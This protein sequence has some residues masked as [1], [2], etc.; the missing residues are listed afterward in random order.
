MEPEEVKQ[1]RVRLRNLR[2]EDEEDEEKYEEYDEEDE[3]KYEEYE[4]DE[5]KQL[6]TEIQRPTASTTFNITHN[7]MKRG[8]YSLPVLMA[9]LA[10]I[11]RDSPDALNL[12]YSI[13]STNN[14]LFTTFFIVTLKSTNNAIYVKG[15]Q[16]INNTI[17]L[18]TIQLFISYI[19]SVYILLFYKTCTMSY[20]IYINKNSALFIDKMKKFINAQIDNFSSFIIESVSDL[21]VNRDLAREFISDLKVAANKNL[22]DGISLV[23][24]C[25]SF[26]ISD[27][28]AINS[29][30]SHLRGLISTADD[31]LFVEGLE[32]NYE[33]IQNY[34]AEQTEIKINEAKKG[35][36]ES[37]TDFIS[38]SNIQESKDEDEEQEFKKDLKKLIYKKNFEEINNKLIQRSKK[39]REKI[40]SGSSS[41]KSI[42]LYEN[43]LG[44]LQKPMVEAL[45]Y[46]NKL[47]EAQNTR[48][49]II[50]FL[51]NLEVS[52]NKIDKF[53][54]DFY[55]F[56]GGL[57]YNTGDIVNKTL[58]DESTLQMKNLLTKYNA[59]TIGEQAVK[60]GKNIPY[61]LYNYIVKGETSLETVRTG[62]N[63]LISNFL[64]DLINSEFV[65]NSKYFKKALSS[66]KF[67]NLVDKFDF[68]WQS[69]FKD[70]SA[71]LAGDRYNLIRELDE[72]SRMLNILTPIEIGAGY[73]TGMIKGIERATG[74]ITPLEQYEKDVKKYYNTLYEY[75]SKVD[76]Y[77]PN[78]IEPFVISAEPTNMFDSPA[79]LSFSLAMPLAAVF[80]V[81]FYI[82][83]LLFRKKTR[84]VQSGFRFEEEN[85]ENNKLDSI[86]NKINFI[87]V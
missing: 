74:I 21:N 68:G 69:I 30:I 71:T 64:N 23:L 47:K 33:S 31:N 45:N 19:V 20:D 50:N 35:L 9:I 79:T 12:I 66:Q 15:R 51:S 87:F 81:L 8:A 75:A 44:L 52:K 39:L 56:M 86:V 28:S 49:T 5:V 4:E 61:I 27:Y 11:F 40:S 60:W 46:S 22:A 38:S 83:M 16:F 6:V 2:K 17:I 77:V 58:I 53:S 1:S 72:S 36:W 85:N 32:Y 26:K 48:E 78:V 43:K 25:L 54:I 80:F 59:T 14:I 84:P 73:V 42:T 37:I 29:L 41:D 55:N 34:V 24:V 67:A 13:F 63:I 65:K 82:F 18:T 57:S 76:E 3:E 7:L 62:S 70:L 10:Y